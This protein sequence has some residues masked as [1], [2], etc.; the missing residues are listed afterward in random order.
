M[1]NESLIKKKNAETVTRT[2]VLRCAAHSP[3]I[4]YDAEF[5]FSLREPK[6]RGEVGVGPGT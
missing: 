4:D 1:D 3:T 5:F 6:S 2:S